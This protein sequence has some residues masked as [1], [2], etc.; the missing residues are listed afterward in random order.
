[1]EKLLGALLWLLSCTSGSSYGRKVSRS[2]MFARGGRLSACV[3]VCVPPQ[4]VPG[5]GLLASAP[6]PT[7]TRLRGASDK[8]PPLSVLFPDV[9]ERG[10]RGGG[11]DVGTGLG[12]VPLP[13][14]ARRSAHVGE[15]GSRLVV[16]LMGPQP[17]VLFV[18]LRRLTPPPRLGLGGHFLFSAQGSRRQQ[19]NRRF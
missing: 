2:S 5:L 13:Q 4:K 15:E 7:P 17:E 10:V 9:E 18:S 19:N 11:A 1:M 12:R 8:F 3:C 16:M 14:R 6:C